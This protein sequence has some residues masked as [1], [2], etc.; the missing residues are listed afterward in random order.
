MIN[1]SKALLNVQGEIGA[2]AKDSK[3]PFFKSNYLSLNGVRE[4]V[5]PV[6]SKNRV[7]LLQP[8]VFRDGKT[9]V[10]T[11]LIHADTAEMIESLTEV[12]TS[13][14]GDAQNF[15]SGLSYSRR[16]GL[17]SLLCLSAEDDDGEAAVGRKERP[18]LSEPMVAK[19]ATETPKEA[20]AP[21]RKVSFSNKVNTGDDI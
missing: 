2:I 7:V 19:P 12:V 4:A 13:K 17:M 10:A 21:K 3:N 18:K 16:Y 5:L 9:F 8:T 14:V 20:E 15:G 6:L 11:Q 1:L